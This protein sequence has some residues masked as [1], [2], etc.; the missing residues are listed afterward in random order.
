MP[1][2]VQPYNPNWPIQFDQIAATIRP[3]LAHIP[4]ATIEHVGSTSV[5]DLAAKP[6]LDI[7]II[8][9]PH[10]IPAGIDALATLGYI[11]RGDLGVPGR[12]AFYA[13][14]DTPK[15]HLYLCERDCL[16]VRNH[17]AVRDILRTHPDLR[18]EYGTIKHT[19]A[20]D[21]TIDIDTYIAGKSDILQKIL[22]LAC[23]ITP[24]ERESILD[25]NAK[26]FPPRSIP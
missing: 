3:A 5:P 2:E 24:E 22:A 23:N 20:A 18:D 17:L 19:L 13:P 21:P 10:D 15:H 8:V 12:E 6:I 11:H 1:I 16:S 14:D 26:T 7:D 9:D 25:V 4:H